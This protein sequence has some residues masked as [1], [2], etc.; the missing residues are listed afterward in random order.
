MLHGHP[1][2][3]PTE[4]AGYWQVVGAFGARVVS[5]RLHGI[6]CVNAVRVDLGRVAGVVVALF[7][8]NKEP[9][10]ATAKRFDHVP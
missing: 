7:N 9:S 10:N 5:I 6:A 8:A 1:E 3:T 4:L 2:L